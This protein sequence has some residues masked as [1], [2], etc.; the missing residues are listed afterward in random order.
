MCVH[1]W[2]PAGG[3][4]ASTLVLKLA[5]LDATLAN[6]DPVRHADELPVG[7][8]GAR[9]LAAVVKDDVDAGALERRMERIG[10]LSYRRRPVVADRADDDGERRDSRGKT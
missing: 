6:H 10:R 7:E 2:R 1:A 5:V 3:S 8:H 9:T 4:V